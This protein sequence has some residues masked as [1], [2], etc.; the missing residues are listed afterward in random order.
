MTL[1]D[2]A[3]LL[4]N[5]L[6]ATSK[7]GSVYGNSIGLTVSDGQVD[8]SSILAASLKGPFVAQAGDVLP[9]TP[10][11]VYRNGEVSDSAE[12][13]INDVYY[14]SESLN[15]LWIYTNKARAGSPPCPPTPPPPPL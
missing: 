7:S 12:L 1:T 13:H 4:Y 10:T 8:T 14:Y 5:T 2:C 3:V 11:T 15:S 9:I 6:T